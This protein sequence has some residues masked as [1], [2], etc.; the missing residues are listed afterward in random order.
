MNSRAYL[1][2][3]SFKLNLT[4][5]SIIKQCHTARPTWY[6]YFPSV[7]HYY[8]EV[9]CVLGNLMIDYSLDYLERNANYQNW[10]DEARSLKMM[11]F[12][13]NAKSLTGYFPELQLCWSELYTKL[14][15]G[16]A[17]ILGPILKLSPDRTH[18]F[19]RNIAN[20][21][22][23]HKELFFADMDMFERFVNREYAL[24]LAEQNN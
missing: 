5:E 16:Y 20:E 10:T 9:V 8:N 6:L 2:E 7:K 12:L 1:L 21:I 15:N 24:F 18:L 14:I 3:T 23:V 4:T 13:S 11:V 22:I 17:R 19:M